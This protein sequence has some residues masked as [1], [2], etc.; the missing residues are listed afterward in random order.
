[1]NDRD[2]ATSALSP[3]LARGAFVWMAAL[4]LLWTAAWMVLDAISAKWQVVAPALL[5]VLGAGATVAFGRVLG[6]NGAG[7]RSARL[8]FIATVVLA[9]WSYVAFIVT[10]VVHHS[11]VGAIIS[12]IVFGSFV[13]VLLSIGCFCTLFALLKIGVVFR[14]RGAPRAQRAVDEGDARR[15][16]SPSAWMESRE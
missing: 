3:R 1:M 7:A 16:S 4:T 5:I 8:A 10:L 15:D 12:I 2:H 14:Q 6:A 13:A 11:G 9:T